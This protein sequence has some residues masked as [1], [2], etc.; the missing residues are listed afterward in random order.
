MYNQGT[1]QNK[2]FENEYRC[3][4]KKGDENIHHL[5]LLIDRRYIRKCNGFQVHPSFHKI[6]ARRQIQKMAASQEINL[7][8]PY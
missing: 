5:S 1:K 2:A 6:H 3:R 7:L 8:A 4:M